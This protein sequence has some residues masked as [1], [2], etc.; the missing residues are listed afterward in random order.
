MAKRKKSKETKKRILMRCASAVKKDAV[1][2]EVIDGQEHIIISSFT[3]PDNIVMNGVLYPALEIEK[4]FQSLERT[5]APIGHP[6][7]EDGGFLSASDPAA[8]NNFYAGAYN[9]NVQQVNG[10]VSLDKVINVNEAS[11][12]ERGRQLLERVEE[13]ESNDNAR[14]IHTSTGVF[15]EIDH[16]ENSSTFNGA[17][18]NAEYSLI[19]KNLVF[20][21][22]AI[23][24]NEIGAAQPHQGVGM[25]VNSGLEIHNYNLQAASTGETVSA[26]N[27]DEKPKGD[28]M[29]ELI[30]AALNAAKVKTEGLDDDQLLEA[31]TKLNAEEEKSE[32]I[33]TN[34]TDNETAKA[35]ARIAVRLDSM[36]VALNEKSNDEV[37]QLATIV[38]ESELYANLDKGEAMKLG[39]DTLKAMAANCGKSFGLNTNDDAGDFD[40]SGDMPE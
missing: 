8:I 16:V 7:T 39:Y 17:E 27:D 15:L 26:F 36:E 30:L 33:T 10:R 24:L 23:L 21:H 3:M 9:D 32:E 31:F 19:A 5:L 1:K 18:T 20:D 22:D 2:R 25:A 35:L 34:A 37:E 4:S 40:Y 38:G 6:S 29:K 28:D 14:P 13:I 12:T 11:K